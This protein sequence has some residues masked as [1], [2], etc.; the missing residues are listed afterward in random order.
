M[1]RL[2]KSVAAK[3]MTTAANLG[4][5]DFVSRKRPKIVVLVHQPLGLDGHQPDARARLAERLSDRAGGD[6]FQISIFP[7][8]VAVIMAGEDIMHAVSMEEIQIPAASGQRDV[9]ILILFRGIAQKERVVLEN[10]HV[11]AGGFGKLGF[12]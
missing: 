12:K 10:N 4:M 3:A 8:S 9:K 1:G 11:P 2:A 7:G 6:H 5:K